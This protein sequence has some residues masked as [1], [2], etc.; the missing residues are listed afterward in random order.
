[1]EN[2]KKWHEL[3][4]SELTQTSGGYWWIGALALAIAVLNTD[5]DQAAKDFNRGYESFEP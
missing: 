4:T 1:M 5:W 3:G 2:T